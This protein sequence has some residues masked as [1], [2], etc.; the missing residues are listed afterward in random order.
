MMMMMM[1]MK[2]ARR[3]EQDLLGV[4]LNDH[5]AGATV[6]V[7]L[8]RRMAASAEPGSETAGVVKSLVK[9][10]TADRS[11]LVKMMAAVGVKI[12]GYKVFA[13]WAGEKA[14]RLKLNGHVL[15]RSPLSALEETE[16]LRLGVDGKAAGWRTLRVVAR[17][18]S[19]LDTGQLDELLARAN[20]Q[21]DTLESL[22]VGIAERVLADDNR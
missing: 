22:R 4:Y 12:R 6:G 21:S 3:T 8:V 14:G 15:S 7:Q 13:A 9:E 10:I 1:A 20:R 19:R 5:L 2:T 17:R 11:A 18:D 16:M